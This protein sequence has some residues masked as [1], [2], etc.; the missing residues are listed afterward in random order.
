MYYVALFTFTKRG[1]LKV[2]R[3]ELDSKKQL[4]MEFMASKTYR[5][6][7]VKEMASVLMV[8]S[9]QKKTCAK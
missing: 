9:K 3:E 7:S 2:T 6:M 4:I 5:P 1:C 8:P